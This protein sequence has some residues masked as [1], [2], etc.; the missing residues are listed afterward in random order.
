LIEE[1]PD[2]WSTICD[3]TPWATAAPLGSE[4]SWSEATMHE[5]KSFPIDEW[6]QWSTEKQESALDALVAACRR[7][8]F[9]WRAVTEN[10]GAA[11]ALGAVAR[12]P[13]RVRGDI[14]EHVGHAG[15][16]TC[17][18]A[19]PHR[20]EA[21]YQGAPSVVEGYYNDRILRRA[22]RFQLT[23]A[24]PVT[25]RRLLRAL[26]AQ[27]RAPLN[28]PPSLARWIV[29]EYA[30]T[31]GTVLDPCSGYGG[32]LLGALASERNVRYVGYDVEP[33]SV[34]GNLRLA[35]MV[36]ASD[37]VEQHQQAVEDVVQYPQA[38]LALVGPP[39][40]DRENYG[41]AS[42]RL[43]DQYE[44][45]DEWVDGFLRIL[46]RKVLAA[47]SCTVVNIAEV[48]GRG[49]RPTMDYP[50]LVIAEAECLGRR[51]ERVLDWKLSAFVRKAGVEKLIVI[52]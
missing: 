31:D 4:K 15:Q 41:A 10:A 23:Y 3:Q 27:L 1:A 36:G 25:P 17:L 37:R 7:H 18:A 35:E 44:S 47:A 30:P 38:D 20:L 51:V 43:L 5:L 14:I 32:R 6:R 48:R 13:V 49:W 22:M 9:P 40:F 12:N 21:S 45:P 16:R 26:S 29:D 34:A 11:E 8:D 50:A 28:F 46:V 52:V 42:R 2:V 24:D 19:H 39:Y 33:K